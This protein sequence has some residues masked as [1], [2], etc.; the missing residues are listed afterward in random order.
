MSCTQV[1]HIFATESYWG[2]LTY[3]AQCFLDSFAAPV[4]ARA[5][6]VSLLCKE[7]GNP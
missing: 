5:Q 7:E 6:C 1:Q 2:V 3:V 4:L